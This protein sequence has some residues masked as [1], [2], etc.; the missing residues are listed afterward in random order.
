MGNHDYNSFPNLPKLLQ[1]RFSDILNEKPFSHKIING[2]H[3][4]NW[5]SM[6]GTTVTCNINLNW[7]KNQIEIA[8]KED[9]SKP[10]FV[11]T[12]LNPKGT[13]YGSEK[14]W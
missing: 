6:D 14:I 12:H 4:I 3:F 10:I 2:F 1:K 11:T 8:L 5:S 9:S 13:I 7:I